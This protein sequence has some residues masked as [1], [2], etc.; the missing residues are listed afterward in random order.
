M[1][2]ISGYE[3]N[4]TVCRRRSSQ[5]K[6]I[7]EIKPS[8]SNIALHFETLNKKLWIRCVCSKVL[9]WIKVIDFF[10]SFINPYID[11]YI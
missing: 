10:V 2:I 4:N 1:T 9:F 3:T 11:H 8:S 6:C 5:P 7:V